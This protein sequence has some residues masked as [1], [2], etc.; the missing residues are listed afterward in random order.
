MKKIVILFKKPFVFAIIFGVLLMMCNGYVLLKTFYLPSVT[1]YV[2]NS[3]QN[4]TQSS[5]QSNSSDNSNSNKKKHNRQNKTGKHNNST[6]NN[7]NNSNNDNNN[8]DNNNNDNNNNDNNNSNNDSNAANNSNDTDDN[9]T[10]DNNNITDTSYTDE[11]ISIELKTLRE[12]D[13]DIYI[14]DITLSSADYLKTAL[15]NNMVGTNITQKTSEIAQSNNAILAI[16]GDYY[17]ANRR[18][19]VIKNGEVYRDTVRKDSEYQD[20]AIYKDGS[21]DLIYEKDVSA[22]ELLENGVVNLFAFGPGLVK[23]GE[24]IISEGDE[25]GK[26]MSDNPRT[27]IGIIDELHFCMMVSDGRTSQSE[28]LS[29][30]EVAHILQDYGCQTAY[31]LDGG[32]SSTMYFNGE[33]INNPTTNGKKI[34]ERSVSDI[35]YIGY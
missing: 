30:Y 17:G 35:V 29:L 34:S 14:A 32:G 21:F 24:I 20:L 10:N 23:N 27:A 31:N 6:D 28:G 5:T 4:N 11:N 26:A 9:N 33:I 16:N 3:N 19:Y 22:Q 1:G 13:T 25:V 8:N 7:D 2:V 12:Y 18:G 15:A